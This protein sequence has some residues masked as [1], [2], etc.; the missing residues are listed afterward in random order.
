M[1]ACISQLNLQQNGWLA[2]AYFSPNNKKMINSCEELKIEKTILNQVFK[3]LFRDKV[4][5]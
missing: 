2:P 5:H 4:H 1:P 3:G